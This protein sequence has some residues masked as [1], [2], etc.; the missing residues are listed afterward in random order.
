MHFQNPM[1]LPALFIERAHQRVAPGMNV[2]RH[3]IVSDPLVRKLPD[4]MTSDRSP[5]FPLVFRSELFDV[6]E[7]FAAG[8]VGMV[9]EI[10]LAVRKCRLDVLAHLE[11]QR[12]GAENERPP[13]IHFPLL[14]DGTEIEK[15][16]VVFTDGVVGRILGVRKERIRARAN[17]ALVPVGLDSIELLSKR[18]NFGVENALRA[19]WANQPARFHFVK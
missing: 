7:E 13:K 14:E 19:T 1:A 10:L 5:P 3:L 6:M 18:V 17:D 15:Q 16:N 12:I 8:S 11:F 4:E 9:F 2:E